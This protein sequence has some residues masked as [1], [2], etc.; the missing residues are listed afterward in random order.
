[1]L[2]RPPTY[3]DSVADL[4][5]PSYL[6]MLLL[7][8]AGLT[9]GTLGIG[10]FVL[11]LQV[12]NQFF[13]TVLAVASAILMG[14]S[15][16]LFRGGVQSWRLRKDTRRPILFLRSFSKDMTF[17]RTLT[18]AGSPMPEG[19]IDSDQSLARAVSSLGPLIGIGHRGETLP[20]GGAARF[21]VDVDHWKAVVQQ[22]VAISPLVILRIGRGE[23]FWWEF[24]H[25]AST[26]EPER[27]LLF[28]RPT[29]SSDDYYGFCR[30]VKKVLSVD[31]PPLEAG[32]LFLGFSPAWQPFFVGL[33]R[34]P[35][36]ARFRF[37]F[38]TPSNLLRDALAT[39]PTIDD[40]PG[41]TRIA[42]NDR[43]PVP[44]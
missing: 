15:F 16:T 4:L 30:R 34:G 41:R 17:W 37:L 12:D 11:G 40:S 26:C 39:L 27:V 35:V 29:P 9:S 23:G 36:S 42:F 20:P 22:L 7:A 25:V 14:I 33:P 21:Y 1:V 38:I 19:T 31:L 5:P 13:R 32:A 2:S 44:K 6:R 24:E 18:W 10:L 28:L 3:L 43:H 8:C